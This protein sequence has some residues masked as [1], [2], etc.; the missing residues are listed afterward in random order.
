M[1]WDMDIFIAVWIQHI[2][3]EN[4]HVPGHPPLLTRHYPPTLETST[5]PTKNSCS[6]KNCTK[7]DSLP[8]YLLHNIDMWHLG[9]LHCNKLIPFLAQLTQNNPIICAST[10]HNLKYITFGYY[11]HYDV[12]LYAWAG[13]RL[14]PHTSYRD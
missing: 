1:S 9:I 6:F 4:I 12:I 14:R 7:F 3:N 13:R 2:S 8:L 11:I 10:Y 5:L